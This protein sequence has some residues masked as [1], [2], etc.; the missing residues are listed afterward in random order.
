MLGKITDEIREASK[1]AVASWKVSALIHGKRFSRCQAFAVVPGPISAGL[2][3]R[4]REL[5]R[6]GS[7]RETAQTGHSGLPRSSCLA[8]CLNAQVHQ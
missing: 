3:Y 2:T 4:A 7:A 6:L 1:G 8:V 5:G